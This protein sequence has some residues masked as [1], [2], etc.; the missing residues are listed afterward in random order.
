MEAEPVTPARGPSGVQPPGHHPG[1]VTLLFSDVVGSTALKQT[2]GDRAGVALLQQHHE[3]VRQV[4]REFAGAEVIKT[5]GDSFL[6]LFPMPSEAVRCALVLQGRLRQ[7]NQGQA[8]AV[9]DRL[10]LHTGEVV[11]EEIAPGQRDV[12]GMQVDTCSR[13][14]GL[15]PGGQILMTRGVFDS[16][17]QM[18]KGEDIEGV[19]SLSWVSHGRYLVKGVEEPVEICEVAEAGRSPL[20][21]PDTTEKAQR[22]SAP[23]EEPVLGWRPAVGTVVPN[24]N[25]VLEE[26]LGEGGFGEVWLGR[27]QAMKERRV[28]K[29]CFRADRARSLK[30]EMTL[31]RLI[32]ERIGEH[33][34]IVALREVYFE[35]PPFYVEVDYVAGQDLRKW[36]DAQGGAGKVPLEVKLEVVAQVAEAL[37]A[38]HDAGVIHRDVKPANILV[39]NP[40]GCA[41]ATARRESEIRNPKSGLQHPQPST[42]NPQPVVKLTDFGIG[43]VVSQECLAG[44]TRAGFTQTM[45]SP[46]SSSQTGTHLY[47]APELLAGEPASTRSDIYSL[48]VVLYQL[49][50]GAFNRPL[51]TEWAEDVPDPLLREDIGRCVAGKPENRFAGAGQLAERLRALPQRRAELAARQQAER[52]RRL[53]R[54]TAMVILLAAII[55]ASAYLWLRHSRVQW[56]KHQAVPEIERLTEEAGPVWDYAKQ[57]QALRLAEKALRYL[58]TEPRLQKAIEAVSK[59]LSIQSEPAGAAVRIKPYDNQDEDWTLLGQTPLQ[60]IRLPFGF[61]IMRF[62]K[63]GYEPVEAVC[64]IALVSG[65]ISRRLDA[66]NTIPAGMVRVPGW[67]VAGSERFPDFFIDKYEV[68]NRRFKEFVDAGGYQNSRYWKEPFMRDGKV[69]AWEEAMSLFRDRSGRPGPATWASGEY[70]EGRADYPVCGVSWYEAAAYAEFAGKS[71]PTKHHWAQAAGFFTGDFGGS[72]FPTLISSLSNFGTNGP[73]SV[74]SHRGM[75]AFGALDMAGNVREWCWNQSSGG[76]FIRGGAWNDA[77]YMYGNESQQSPWDRSPRNGFRCVFYLDRDKI[78]ATAFEPATAASRRDFAKEKPVPDSVFD[79]YKAQFQYDPIELKAVVEERDESASDWR[80]EKV[81]F[82]AAYDNERVIAYLYLPRNGRKPWQSV[83]YF[84]GSGAV[85]DTFGVSASFEAHLDYFVRNGRAVVSPVYKGAYERTG[86]MTFAKRAPTEEYRYAYTGFL[87]KWVKDFRRCVDYLETRPDFDR[88]KI[89][90]F[91]F[92]W[93]GIMGTIIPAVEPRIKANMLVLGGLP[94]YRAQPEAQGLNY[95][96]RI[97]VPTLMLNGKYDMIFPLETAVQ[98]AFNLLGT[99]EKDKKLIIYDTDHYV[100]KQELSKESLAWL[101]RYLGPAK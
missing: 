70:A 63:A 60:K 67:E 77:V 11:I 15:A 33:P 14:M 50:V 41:R 59:V 99:P 45:M 32:K 58:P 36:C 42:L 25:W 21:P 37:Q 26:K 91:G 76:R 80:R 2:L 31:F 46:G 12:H 55:T 6:I 8:A 100:P 16:A 54:A 7:F 44:V 98:P 83:I 61:F 40:T 75:N 62:D 1:L 47:M 30:R 86:D 71:L 89:A 97:K 93:G 23:D 9:Q 94:D 65:D 69:L 95:I 64:S 56:A 24:T 101:D 81:T 22:Q 79:I 52:R 17:R 4:L 48:G 78:P 90:F 87:A 92:S 39:G 88:Q 13:V 34:N 49:V 38:A 72:G 85:A 84:P 51:T 82:N 3:L 18:L 43:Q 35:E 29:F 19:G 53:A 68:T 74:G 73:A 57:R 66:T 28:F 10:G 96:S 27:H 20:R 5:A